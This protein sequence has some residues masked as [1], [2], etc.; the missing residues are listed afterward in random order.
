[1][2]GFNTGWKKFKK[3]KQNPKSPS[4]PTHVY[5][6]TPASKISQIHKCSPAYNIYLPNSYSI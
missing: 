6:P 3:K 1:M 4:F 2:L 5:F